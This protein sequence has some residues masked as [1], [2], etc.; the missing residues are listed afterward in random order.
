VIISQVAIIVKQSNLS[1]GCVSETIAIRADRLKALREQRGWSQRELARQCSMGDTAISMYE[2]ETVEPTAKHLKK[3]AETLNVSA[4]YL[5]GLT[6]DPLGHYGSA[7]ID[8]D[9]R[10]I[11]RAFRQGRWREVIQVAAAHW[12]E[13]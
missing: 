9:E 5:L 8:D 3:M 7:E 2:R 10:A 12:P 1:R 4:D 13:E 11:I 6:D